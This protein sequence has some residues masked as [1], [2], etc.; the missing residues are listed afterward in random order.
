MEG[1]F[2]CIYL[3]VMERTCFGRDEEGDGG[4]GGGGGGISGIFI[5]CCVYL[6]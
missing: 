4:G 5:L 6:P 1:R 3:G 2:L